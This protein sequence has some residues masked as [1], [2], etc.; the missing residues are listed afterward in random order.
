MC[1][2][3]CVCVCVWVCETSIRCGVHNSAYPAARAAPTID[4]S[5]P[6]IS[7][8]EKGEKRP[9]CSQMPALH[10]CAAV[11]VQSASVEH[12]A[13]VLFTHTYIA[14]QSLIWVASLHGCPMWYDESRRVRDAPDERGG[15]PPV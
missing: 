5:V 13:H 9:L 14:L 4:T 7:R 8:H 6:T 10:T 1:E 12:G 11:A 3:V 2:Y 15:V